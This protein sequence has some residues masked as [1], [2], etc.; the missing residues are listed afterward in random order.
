M[1]GRPEC[2]IITLMIWQKS[3]GGD[4]SWAMGAG[5]R[6]EKIWVWAWIWVWVWVCGARFVF[7]GVSGFCLSLLCLFVSRSILEML[8]E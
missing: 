6:G 4:E 1:A 2:E 7:G 3:D 5:Q 8:A